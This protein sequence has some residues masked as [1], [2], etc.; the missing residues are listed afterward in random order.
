MEKIKKMLKDLCPMVSVSGHEYR[1]CGKLIEKYKTYFDESYS[2]NFGNCVFVKKSGKPNAKKL[3]ID[4]HFDEVG[5]FVTSIEDGGFIHI[6]NV[7]GLDGR[8]FP[9]A[10]VT[11]YG[12]KEIYGVV[13]STPPHLQT[14]ESSK[15]TPKIENILIDTGY[16]K[17]ELE[18]I[19]TPGDPIRLK[20]DYC[21]IANDYVLSRALD[22]KSCVAAALYAL[23]NAGDIL[24]DVYL[25]VSAQEET[26]KGGCRFAA[27]EIKPDIA[28]IA[29]VNFAKCDG[30]SEFQSIKCEEGASV[31]ISS[32][33]D[34]KVTRSVIKMLENK[35]IKHQVICEPD[36]TGT[37]NELVLISGEGIKTL[38]L[39]I[40]L[41]AMHTTSE[42]VSV[43]DVKSLAEVFGAIFTTELTEER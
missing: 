15:S 7:G 2:D 29:D 9:A 3:M 17:E 11:I 30:V 43:K 37:N 39:S 25:I 13:A 32:L 31:D 42:A 12:K 26:G 35:G 20:G 23:M 18:K 4:T 8:I 24:Y 41:M 28:I 5:M 14:K 1:S 21:E 22:N 19:V 40:P 34:R 27:A 33:T 36:S 16:A 6:T 38:V 10:E